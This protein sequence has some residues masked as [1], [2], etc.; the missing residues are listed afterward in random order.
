MPAGSKRPLIERTT[1]VRMLWNFSDTNA[2][3]LLVEFG[4]DF[5]GPRFVLSRPAA[6][7]LNPQLQVN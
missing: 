6:L 4:N 2:G 3:S 5:L 1:S 7:Q